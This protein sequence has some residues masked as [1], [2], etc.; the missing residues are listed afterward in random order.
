MNILKYLNLA[1][2]VAASVE[3]LISLFAVSAP[4]TGPAI[5]LA[6]QPAISAVQAVFPKANIPPALVTDVCDAAAD[7]INAYFKRTGA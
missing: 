2:E 7:A 5:S 3:A 1:L 6:V 4:V